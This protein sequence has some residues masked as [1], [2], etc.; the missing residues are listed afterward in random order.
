MRVL[1]LEAQPG[2]AADVA[3][4]LTAGGHTVVRCDSA[5]DAAPCRGLDVA[6]ECPLDPRGPDGGQ[7]DV[8]V[9]ARVDGELRPA[10]HGALCATR[11]R[12]PLVLVGNG[13]TAHPYGSFAWPAGNDLLGTCAT[14]AASGAAH[15]AAVRRDLLALGIA[16]REELDEIGIEVQREPLRLVLRIHIAEDHPRG[17]A[18]VKAAAESLRRYDSLA[19]V[20][21]VV[22]TG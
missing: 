8:A 18:L 13:A 2:L 1:V 21:D 20:I 10:E 11:Q 4:E 9:V 15:A 22:V 6:G 5:H 14:A 17:D 7:V 19:P 3:A 12:I 16:T